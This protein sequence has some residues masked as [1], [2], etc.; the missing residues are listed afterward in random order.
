MKKLLL[1]LLGLL[2]LTAVSCNKKTTSV[3]FDGGIFN[4]KVFKS[5]TNLVIDEEKG[6][7]SL[8]NEDGI[9]NIE[10][11]IVSSEPKKD[12]LGDDCTLYNLSDGSKY[13]DL[14]SKFFGRRGLYIEPN[15]IRVDIF[16]TGKK[17]QKINFNFD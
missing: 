4:E 2:V 12:N 5:T 10:K 3:K 8:H 16:N 11:T 9:V 7:I 15:G 6:V 14:R 1:P 17:K 13:Y